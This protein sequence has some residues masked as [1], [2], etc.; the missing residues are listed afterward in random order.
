MNFDMALFM[1]LP[2]QIFQTNRPFNDKSADDM[3]C[4]DLNDDDFIRMGITDIS[5]RVNPFKLIRYD[6]SNAYQSFD[7]GFN[8]QIPSGWSISKDECIE[9]LFDEMKE[10]STLFAQDNNKYRIH[11]L[12]EHFHYGDGAPWRS[13]QLDLAYKDII[14]GIGTNDTLL[15]INES[16]NDY[17]I[18]NKNIR[19]DI[20]TAKIVRDIIYNTWLPKFNR[21]EDRYNG[22]GISVHDVYAQEI[23]LIRLQRYALSWEG[24]LHFRGQDHFGLDKTDVTNKIY[25]NF[26]FFRIW[27]FL[28]RH[29]DYAF[30]PFYTNFS[31]HVR[32]EGGI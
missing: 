10:L 26:R 2:C 28:Q 31:A 7:A 29:K 4:G 15:K 14:E 32:I 18:Y 13:M 11:E 24:L 12:I 22:L 21:S 27:F 1:Q 17:F 20:F 3:R 25:K 16:I 9:I 8:S 19:F 6:L 23:T 30:K 5:G